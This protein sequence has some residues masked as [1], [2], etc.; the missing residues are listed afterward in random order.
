MQIK[1]FDGYTV[2]FFQFTYPFVI[3]IFPFAVESMYLALKWPYFFNDSEMVTFI[4]NVLIGTIPLFDATLKMIFIGPYR[5][6]IV[7]VVKKCVRSN[8]I[9]NKSFQH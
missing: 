4:I 6:A 3:C 5:K 7:Q 2:F 9:L 8:R 1:F